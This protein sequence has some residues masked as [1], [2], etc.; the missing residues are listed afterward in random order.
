MGLRLQIIAMHEAMIE[1]MK[2]ALVM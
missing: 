1:C 2:L